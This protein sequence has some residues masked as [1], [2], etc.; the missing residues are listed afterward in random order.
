MREKTLSGPGQFG[1]ARLTERHTWLAKRVSEAPDQSFPAL[2]VSD[3]D[4]EAVY[5]FL[6]NER[7]S[8]G[9]L[10]EPHYELTIERIGQSRTLFVIHDTTELRCCG[11]TQR[12]GLGRLSKGNG[13][14]GFYGHF[15][16]AVSGDGQRQPLGLLGFAAL[17][18]LRPPRNRTQKEAQLDP[19]RKSARWG[20]LVE[21]T[22]HRAA[23][24]AE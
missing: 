6:G 20:N 9:R 7:V 23:G 3:S 17:F 12:D 14:N 1:D 10:L 16:L 18:Q 24:R 2:A 19:D 22:E 11:R 21:G 8:H 13:K 4:L 5:R 15:A